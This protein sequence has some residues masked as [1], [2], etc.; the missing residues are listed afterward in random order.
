[1]PENHAGN[2]RAEQD[3]LKALVWLLATITLIL[4]LVEVS[5]PLPVILDRFLPDDAFYYLK[6]AQ[7]FAT[8]GFSS[9]DGIH[10]TNGYQPLWFLTLVPVFMLFPGGGELPLRLVLLI[11]VCLATV[12]IALL[13]RSVHRLFGIV[14]AAI[15]T[16]G[17]IFW[18]QSALI[19]G[20]ETAL[21]MCI[22]LGLFG[23][24]LH[25]HQTP[26]PGVR[27]YIFLGILSSLVFL[28][29]TDSVFLVAGISLAVLLDPR[30]RRLPLQRA[31][32]FLIAFS[33][34]LFMIAGGYLL[35]NLLSTGHIMPVSGAAKIYYSGLAREHAAGEASAS[36]LEIYA[37]NLFWVFEHRG[38]YYVFLGIAVFLLSTIGSLIPGMI[39]YTRPLLRLWPFFLGGLA[40]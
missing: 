23:Y 12:T 27:E 3:R 14:P 6:P 7:Y 21:L 28:A 20:L 5:A 38:Y 8:Q 37:A 19:N 2:Q 33:L 10:F 11:Q 32:R 24:Y 36:V 29:R 35:T 30:L 31:V 34:P 26:A 16:A 15:A 40:S 18:F 22:Y 4:G 39:R 1:L 13:I 17:W 25:F 9:F